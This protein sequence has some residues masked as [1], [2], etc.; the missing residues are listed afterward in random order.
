MNSQHIN[1]FCRV[2]GK[3]V[4][5]LALVLFVTFSALASVSPR[6]HH[7]LH[8]DDQSP[9]HYCAI[10]VIEHGQA[11]IASLWVSVVPAALG[12]PGS[13]LLCESFFISHDLTLHPERG[14]P[15]LS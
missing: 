15:A 10:T 2:A 4:L 9:S 8:K 12:I 5:A 11:D 6:L 13:A 14:P 3:P 1:A 7:W